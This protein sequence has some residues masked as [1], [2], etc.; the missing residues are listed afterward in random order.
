MLYVKVHNVYCTVCWPVQGVFS[1]SVSEQN[2]GEDRPQTSQRITFIGEGA[3]E[4]EKERKGK[5]TGKAGLSPSYRT[6]VLEG[7][8]N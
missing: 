2:E 5:I 1:Q 7:K 3:R 8:C 4:G 6:L